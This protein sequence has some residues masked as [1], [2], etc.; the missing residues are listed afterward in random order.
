M[1]SDGFP[2]NLECIARDVL[3]VA[4]AQRCLTGFRNNPALRLSA[5]LEG[6]IELSQWKNLL[7]IDDVK[8]ACWISHSAIFVPRT[9]IIEHHAGL[10]EGVVKTVRI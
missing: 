8:N 4:R 3:L 1:T 5:I 9:G 7:F 2:N 6:V 10:F